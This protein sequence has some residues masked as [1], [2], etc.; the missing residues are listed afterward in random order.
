MNIDSEIEDALKQAFGTDLGRL[1]AGAYVLAATAVRVD[2][3]R[4]EAEGRLAERINR[5]T[6]GPE[7]V[8]LRAENA[9]AA[10]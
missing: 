9:D 2:H 5:E 8:P 7:P 10:G 4:R 3:A 1:V 6:S